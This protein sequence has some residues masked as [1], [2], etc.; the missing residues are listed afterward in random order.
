MLDVDYLVVGAGAMGMAF[1]DALVEHADVRVALVD[2]RHAAGGHWLEAYPFVRLHQ[3]SSFYGVA[4]TLLGGGQLQQ[5]GPE[6]GLQ[7]RASRNEICGYYESVLRTLTDSD[8]VRFL[9]AC[10]YVGDRTVV[11]LV[12]GA[13]FTVPEHCRIVNA[14]YL[15]PSIPAEMP[16]PF[17]VED[18]AP[19]IPVNDLARLEGAP[20]E[21]VIAGAGKT[22]TDACVWLLAHGVDPDRIT[23][24]RPREPWMFDRAVVQP[25]P[26]I[27]LGMVATLM[28]A[29]RHAVSPEDFF[30]RLEDAEIMLRID[31]ERVPTMAKAPTLARWE[32][33]QL[34]TLERVVRHG[35]LTSVAPG[36]LDFADASI[37]VALDAVVVHCAGQG[38]K[39]PPLVP[40]WG[41]DEAATSEPDVKAWANGTPLNPTRIPEGYSS[42]ALDDARERLALHTRPGMERLAQLR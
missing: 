37:P 9:S 7:E 35:H 38:L 18:G 11:S 30:L 13:R 39:Y 25:D 41:R 31:R 36:R 28:E 21:Y 17:T 5:D 27:F 23:W 20:S 14:H 34:R 6:Q 19:V 10:E 22:A 16:P 15:A 3:A 24:V 26:A 1:T 4:S 29:G 8:R 42:P 32:L 33:E 12:S 2:R 40:I